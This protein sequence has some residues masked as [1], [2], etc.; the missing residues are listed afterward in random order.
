MWKSVLIVGCL[1]LAG[2]LST[3][4]GGGNGGADVS[5]SPR[6][7]SSEYQGL[8]LEELKEKSSTTSYKEL[9]DNIDSYK[10]KLVWFNG[11]IEKEFEGSTAGTYQIWA[12]VT[13][14][15]EI[16]GWSD[17]MMVL[18]SLDRGPKLPDEAK[19]EFAGIVVGSYTGRFSQNYDEGGT[20]PVTVPLI[21]VV[22][23]AVVSESDR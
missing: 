22:K 9:N 8:S 20:T 19:V 13:P 11:K 5:F 21:S 17:R 16:V 14:P 12:L 10:D 15:S 1:I 23:A 3:F 18:H 6:D 7:V 2:L 4:C